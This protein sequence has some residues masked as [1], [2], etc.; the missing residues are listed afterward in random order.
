VIASIL[1]LSLARTS[2]TAQEAAQTGRVIDAIYSTCTG[3][4]IP[5]TGFI[6]ETFTVT[7]TGTCVMGK[8]RR[9]RRL[10]RAG[11]SDEIVVWRILERHAALLA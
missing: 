11:L 3:E 4:E 8:G 9:S 5:T 6:H 7:Q 2:A 10:W 1:V